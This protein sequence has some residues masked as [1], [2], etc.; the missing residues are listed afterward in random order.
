MPKYYCFLGKS[1][2]SIAFGNFKH[3]AKL[4]NLLKYMSMVAEDCHFKI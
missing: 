3:V 1:V 2:L 4:T